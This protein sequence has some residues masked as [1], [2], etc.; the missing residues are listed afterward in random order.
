[1]RVR[2]DIFAATFEELRDFEVPYDG[3]AESYSTVVGEDLDIGVLW[4]LC[5]ILL[6]TDLD[7][8]LRDTHLV[9]GPETPGELDKPT[10]ELLPGMFMDA[11]LSISAEDLAWIAERWADVPDWRGRHTNEE[12]TM[13][14]VALAELA[15]L[16]V[17]D[18]KLLFLWT[19][20]VDE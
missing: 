7:S 19:C 4:E 8:F 9:S 17:D 3:P 15:S 14:L 5:R 12:L 20:L 11:L 13:Y 16:T 2:T 1:V 6:D 10:V 18:E